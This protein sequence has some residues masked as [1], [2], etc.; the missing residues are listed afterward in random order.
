MEMAGKLWVAKCLCAFIGIKGC[1]TG[2]AILGAD[3]KKN[4]VVCI[5]ST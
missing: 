4:A 2:E 1:H 3:A 5:I